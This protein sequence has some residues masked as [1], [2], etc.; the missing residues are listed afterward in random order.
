MMQVEFVDIHK[1]FAGIHSEFQ[2]LHETN[3]LFVDR[4]E[5]IEA[6]V[7]D[8]KTTLGPLVGMMGMADREINNLDLR[9]RRVERK[10]GISK[11]EK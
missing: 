5:R 6:D 9:L 3:K 4:F 11:L 10:V 8:I 2:K 7:H 1:E